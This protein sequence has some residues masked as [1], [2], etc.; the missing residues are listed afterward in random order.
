MKRFLFIIPLL[1]LFVTCVACMPVLDRAVMREGS[2]KFSLAQLM[3]NPDAYRGKLFILGGVIIGTRFTTAGSQI[4]ALYVPV[5]AYG[6]PKET[7]DAQERFLAVYPRSRG[8]LDPVVY[9]NGKDIT[10]AGTFLEIKTGQIDDI[11]YTYPVFEI[12]EIFLWAKKDALYAYWPWYSYW[13]YYSYPFWWYDPWFAWWG[14][15]SE[16]SWPTAPA[17]HQ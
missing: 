14:P 7:K 9:R 1:A 11:D 3:E 12:R 17:P 8:W 13:P 5:D 4:E 2:R 6:Y 10:L 15:D 16:P